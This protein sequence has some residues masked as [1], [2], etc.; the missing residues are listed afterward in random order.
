M[1]TTV[2]MPTP[3]RHLLPAVD[4]KWKGRTAPEQA[5]V[6]SANADRIEFIDRYITDAEVAEQMPWCF[7][8][9]VRL[10][11]GRCTLR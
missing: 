4:E 10:R 6:A 7:P 9:V 2:E 5:I 8:T 1:T 11:Q 3:T